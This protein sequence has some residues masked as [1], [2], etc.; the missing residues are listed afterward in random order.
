[1]NAMNL[2]NP[3]VAARKLAC[4][5]PLAKREMLLKLMMKLLTQNPREEKELLFYILYHP[6][7]RVSGEDLKRR[8]VEQLPLSDALRASLQTVTTDLTKVHSIMNQETFTE[9]APRATTDGTPL[10]I[11]FIKH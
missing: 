9:S 1:M 3:V 4:Q 10:T 5:L 8:V 6:V 2:L 7:W 11:R